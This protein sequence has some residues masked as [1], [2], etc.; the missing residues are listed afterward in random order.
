LTQTEAETIMRRYF[1]TYRGL[2]GWL[3]DAARKVI[4]ERTARTA[5]GRMYRFRFDENDRRAVSGAQ[6][7]GKN[8]PIQ[9]TSADILKRAL[10]LLHEKISGTSAKLV[11]IVHDEV[12]LECDA[13]EAEMSAKNLEDAMCAAGEE[14]IKKVPVKVDVHIA[15]E[16]T[17]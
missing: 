14:I 17:K 7:N 12:I 4:T 16:W 15:D 8:F 1:A 2:D 11:N 5:S 10:H 6:R 3:R 9:G 13:G